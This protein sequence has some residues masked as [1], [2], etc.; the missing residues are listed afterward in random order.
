MLEL[1][2]ARANALDDI[3]DFQKDISLQEVLNEYD[4]N[5]PTRKRI[6]ASNALSLEDALNLLQALYEIN[7]FKKVAA[8]KVIGN[9]TNVSYGTDGYY[10]RPK[11]DKVNLHDANYH[12]RCQDIS[13][14]RQKLAE[15][16][17]AAGIIDT[18]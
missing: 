17:K 3:K 10:I 18:L 1:G 11:G 15:I 5:D 2:Q 8:L 13:V 14:F 7:A 4:T 6:E 12:I 9:Y 16:K